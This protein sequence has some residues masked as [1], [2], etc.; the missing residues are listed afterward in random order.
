MFLKNRD[1]SSSF[2]RA[3]WKLTIQGLKT[4]RGVAIFILE[5]WLRVR[6]IFHQLPERNP[7]GGRGGKFLITWNLYSYYLETRFG[8]LLAYRRVYTPWGQ[9]P[10]R[11]ARPRFSMLDGIVDSCAKKTSNENINPPRPLASGRVDP[12][13]A[14]SFQVQVIKNLP[15]YPPGG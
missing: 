11:I 4:M 5:W 15:P 12:P 2:R 9:G 3:S 14:R 10:R 13:K 6:A 8:L 7:W 1:T